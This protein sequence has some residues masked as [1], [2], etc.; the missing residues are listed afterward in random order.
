MCMYT[1]TISTRTPQNHRSQVKKKKKLRSHEIW[2][3]PHSPRIQNFYLRYSKTYLLLYQ[4]EQGAQ[5][6]YILT[7]IGFKNISPKHF[8]FCFLSNSISVH[9]VPT[10]SDDFFRI[11]YFLLFSYIALC[12]TVE[13]LFLRNHRLF[14]SYQYQN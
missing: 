3:W 1:R 8:V 7:L 6:H 11:F 9:C 14:S 4:I 2:N 12:R 13:K 5:S 10:I